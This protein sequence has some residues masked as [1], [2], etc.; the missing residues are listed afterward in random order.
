MS[1]GD[2]S[3]VWPSSDTNSRFK[4]GKKQPS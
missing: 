3:E 2:V 4:G 1:L